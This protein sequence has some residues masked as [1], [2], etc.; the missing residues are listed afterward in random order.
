MRAQ[1]RSLVRISWPTPGRRPGVPEND[2]SVT[3][4]RCEAAHPSF[5][6]ALLAAARRAQITVPDEEIPH[7]FGNVCL[8]FVVSLNRATDFPRGSPPVDLHIV[9]SKNN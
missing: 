9:I 4:R 1:V 3:I 5:T 6:C 8:A 2:K 7:E